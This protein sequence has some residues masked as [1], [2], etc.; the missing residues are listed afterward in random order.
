MNERL[1]PPQQQPMP[2]HTGSMHPKP[3][4]GENTYKG[5]GKLAGKKAIITGG[6]SGIGRAVAIAYSRADLLLSYLDEHEDGMK[7]DVSLRK[8]VAKRF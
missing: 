8:R 4:H 1:Q 6:D 3:D 2:G 5:S 7:P